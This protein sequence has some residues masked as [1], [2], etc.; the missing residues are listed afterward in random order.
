METLL[1]KSDWPEAKQR[2]TAWWNR[3]K[4]DR[5][6]LTVRSPRDGAADVPAPARPATIEERWTDLDYLDALNDYS[7][8]TEFYGAEAIPIWSPGYPGHAGLP[9]FYGC[10]FTLDW[11]TG[12]HKPILDGPRLDTSGL[13]LD[14]SGR[15][16]VWGDR[17]LNHA[18]EVS[19]GKS[20]AAMNAIFG[21]G[22]TLAALRE[23]GRLLLDLMDE[24]QAVC[25]AELKLM[26]DWIEVFGH[27][28]G[29]LT[30]NGGLATTWFGLWAPGSCYTA[31]CDVSYGISPQS[32]R[33]CFVPALRK[34]TDFLDYS[35]Y[36]VDGIGAFHL[37]DDIARIGRIR[38]MQILPGTGK[39][40]PLHYLDVLRKVQRLGMGL[41]ITIGADEVEEALAL[42]SSR[43]LCIDTW[44]RSEAHAR[45]IIDLAGRKS[46]DRG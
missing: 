5:C 8:R 43:G 16:W 32:F 46:V 20:I 29:I 39:P 13:R 18:R 26:D 24:P 33:E 35:I 2:L 9:T 15:W 45:E 22:D 34:Q 21:V 44:A 40:S 42:L 6:L 1:Y 30:R 36:H 28:M 3:E 37:V 12:W 19:A 14:R 23:T 11:D 17:M 27:Q 4:L 7:H 41:H 25:E 38:A 10:P 31:H